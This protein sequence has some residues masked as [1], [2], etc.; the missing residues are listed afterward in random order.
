MDKFIIYSCD[1]LKNHGYVP[2]VFPE[3]YLPKDIGPEQ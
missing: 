3:A 2:V 1:I